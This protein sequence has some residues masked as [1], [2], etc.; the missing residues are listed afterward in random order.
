MIVADSDAAKTEWIN[1]KKESDMSEVNVN[2]RT[3]SENLLLRIV[4]GKFFVSFFSWSFC[5]STIDSFPVHFPNYTLKLVI[6]HFNR[7]LHS[8]YAT[9][10]CVAI[11]D[12]Q[13]VRKFQT[14]TKCACECN[15]DIDIHNFPHLEMYKCTNNVYLIPY[16]LHKHTQYG[17]LHNVCIKSNGLEIVR[18]PS[19]MNRKKLLNIMKL[20]GA[21]WTVNSN[22][23]IEL[24]AFCMKCI[25]IFHLIEKEMRRH[26][27]SV[28]PS[29][30]LFP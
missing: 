25:S 11:I 10:R 3:H 9:I 22:W 14:R 21:W 26:F 12:T 18:K 5:F 20:V 2:Y 23:W 1:F 19:R 29:F 24:N 4:D 6:H 8:L 13:M 15:R 27:F 16:T 17:Q 28:L 30:I 7:Q